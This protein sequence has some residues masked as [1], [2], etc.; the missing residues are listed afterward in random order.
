MTTAKVTGKRE[1]GGLQ[2]G[3]ESVWGRL[4]AE[5]CPLADGKLAAGR[6]RRAVSASA[7]SSQLVYPSAEGDG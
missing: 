4:A 3:D 6:A 5:V 2:R 7:E 1:G